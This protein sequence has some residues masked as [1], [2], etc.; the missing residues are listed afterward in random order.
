M[1][2]DAAQAIGFTV[3]YVEETLKG[4]GALKG[5]KGDPGPQGP[6]G[7]K[8]E[9]GEAGLQGP[10][11][12]QGEQ[13]PE[14]PMGPQGPAGAD[15]KDGNDGK[16][17]K[18]V[19][20]YYLASSSSSGVTTSTYGWTETIQTISPSNKYL[21]NYEKITYTDNTTYSTS[22]MIIGV[23]GTDGTNG[24]GIKSIIEYYVLSRTSSGV[25]TSTS[26]WSTT[27]PTLTP[28]DKYL[29]NYELITYTDNSTS[30]ST[31]AIIGVYGD[32][33]ANGK[34]IK[35]VTNYYLAS[36]S[37]SGVTVSTSG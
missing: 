20:N 32:K 34:G 3:K 35:S 7:E 17:I 6:Q 18:T 10:Q 11:G 37:S 24:K 33:G 8:G 9:Q 12:L 26:G 13:G 29:W 28:T 36:A 14:G 15:G 1:N 5:E 31:P 16:G 27:V 21:W 2:A 19:T 4:A 30:S 23:H 22:P 25:T